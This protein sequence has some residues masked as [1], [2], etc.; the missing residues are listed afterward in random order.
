VRAEATARA[1]AEFHRHWQIEVD[2]EAE[3]LRG[4]A[5]DLVLADVPYRVLAAARCLVIPA[6][7]LC[8]LNWAAI[9]RHYCGERPEAPAIGQQMVAAYDDADAFLCPTPSMT[10]AELRGPRVIGPIVWPARPDPDG[11]RRRLGAS[12]DQRLV[13]AALGGVPTRLDV[14]RWPRQTDNVFLVPA[15]WQARGPGF[16]A[17]ESLGMHFSDV[18]ASCNVVLTKPGYNTLVEAACQGVAVLYAARDDWPEEPF[19]LDWLER[20]ARARRLTQRQLYD[21]DFSADLD[22]LLDQ[23]RPPRPQPTGV[24]EA[25]EL[26][27]ARL[28]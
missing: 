16:A 7:A 11:L 17:I 24:A 4:L 2:Q 12:R 3:R 8:S 27:A 20:H 5:P 22:R 9:Y 15:A 28:F 10:M 26:L 25:V 23:P 1:Y 14:Q 19:L 13:L 21:G 6:L 18:L